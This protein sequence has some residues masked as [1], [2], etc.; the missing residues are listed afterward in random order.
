MGN[1]AITVLAFIAAV[2]V[3]FAALITYQNTQRIIPQA[4]VEAPKPSSQGHNMQ[5]MP[6]KTSQA[7]NHDYAK[8]I[9]HPKPGQP[10]KTFKL[11]ALE[12]NIRI[13]DGSSLAA[14]T[15]NGTVPGQE[16]R[17][18][19]GDFVQVELKNNLREPVTIH[20]H[21]YPLKS[22][23]DGVPGLNQNAIKPGETFIYAFSADM[24]GTYWYHSHQESSVQVDKG[25]YGA[26]IVEPKDWTKPDRDYTLILDEWIETPDSE[27]SA[28]GG[29]GGSSNQSNSMPGMN[30]PA[31]GNGDLV[32]SEEEMMAYMYNV[33][34][35]NGKSAG[36]IE[37]LEA[38]NGERVRLRFINA[39]YRKHGIHIPGQE[40]RVIGSDGQDI[41]NPQIIKDQI[42]MISPGE[43]YDV[44]FVVKSDQNFFIDA[45]D[46]NKYNEQLKIPVKVNESD[47]I[48]EEDKNASYPVFNLISYG[49][50]GNKLFTLD[51]KYDVD[52]KVDLSTDTGNNE[53]KY[54]INGKIFKDLPPLKLK[55]GYIVKMTYVNNSKVDHPM[56]MHGHFFQILSRN[57]Q[58]SKGAV[59]VKDT[60]LINPGE[61]YVV[62]FKADNPGNWVQHCHELHHASAGMM[63]I[64][65]YTD[66]TSNYEPDPNKT[67]NKPE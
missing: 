66:F 11:T 2:V 52:Y 20:W 62:A 48:M 51:G 32:M 63:Q 60:L 24:A 47:K 7:N 13:K 25:L 44:E 17:V 5:S 55:T 35:V 57:G 30:M 46:E 21:G 9:V 36:L 12:T 23:M 14:W 10:V 40:I 54:T 53:L 61:E 56:H 27:Q 1:R 8:N 28:H 59:I 37:P 18:Q 4:I 58:P 33:Y 3:T 67:F 65:E 6:S 22:A 49:N 43:R 64:I 42:L 29:H 41:T 34:T 15:Y 50:G 16:I 38:K 19:Q 31:A 45:H 26:L 39:G